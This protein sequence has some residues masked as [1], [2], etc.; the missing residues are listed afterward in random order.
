M[1]LREPSTPE[2]FVHKYRHIQQYKQQTKHR[3]PALDGAKLFTKLDGTSDFWQ[4]LFLFFCLFM[5][6]VGHRV[7]ADDVSPDPDKIRGITEMPR[8]SGGAGVRRLMGMA[9]YLEKYLG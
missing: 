5:M 8:P 3:H 6:F 7:T 1:T 9:I 2:Y 4:I